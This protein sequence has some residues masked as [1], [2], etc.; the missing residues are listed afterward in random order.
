MQLYKFIFSTLPA[1]ALLIGLTA[2]GGSKAE[3]QANTNANNQSPVVDVTTAQAV[4]R[5][6][7]T[8]LEATGSLASDAQTDVAPTVGGK[9][10]EVNF[11]IGSY[12]NKGDALVRLDNRDAQLKLEQAN[13]QVLQAQSNVIQAQSNVQQAETNVQQVRAQLGL[14]AGKTFDVYQV[15]EVKNGE[16][17]ARTSRKRIR[18]CRAFS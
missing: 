3:N 5:E 18:S 7:P 2:C 15:A 14:P 13:A 4:V 1:I 6:I 9:I 8:Y 12:V 11:D 10:T 16:S 17:R